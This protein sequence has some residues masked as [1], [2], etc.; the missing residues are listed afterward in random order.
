[1]FREKRYRQDTPPTYNKNVRKTAEKL[2]FFP[3]VRWKNRFIQRETVKFLVDLQAF[4]PPKAAER[5]RPAETGNNRI[6]KKARKEHTISATPYGKL[7]RL[8]SKPEKCRNLTNKTY[9]QTS[10]QVKRQKTRI[11]TKPTQDNSP[12]C[13]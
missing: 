7:A 11:K 10:N 5:K 9:R 3:V 13:A 4:S 2:C 12:W 8:R 6:N 1:M